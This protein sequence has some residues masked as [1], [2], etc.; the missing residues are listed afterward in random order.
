MHLVNCGGSVGTITGWP[1]LWAACDLAATYIQWLN[2]WVVIALPA[3]EAT[4]SEG[5]PPLLRLP[6]H[7]ASN[8]G[9]IT[10]APSARIFRMA[11]CTTTAEDSDTIYESVAAVL[12]LVRPAP[13]GFRLA[14]HVLD[15]PLARRQQVEPWI[16]HAAQHGERR[17][18]AGSDHTS[19]AALHGVGDRLAGL[20]RRNPAPDELGEQLLPRADRVLQIHDVL[21]HPRVDEAEVRDRRRCTMG[22][23]LGPQ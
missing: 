12:G 1:G 19:S 8:T 13:G 9:M 10:T 20:R 18:V 14:D 3:T 7:A 17:P 5:T 15:A 4:E 6:P 16:D 23:Q 22:R 21:D 2:A 11:L